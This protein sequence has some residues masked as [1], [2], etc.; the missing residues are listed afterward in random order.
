MSLLLQMLSI[1]LLHEIFIFL[2][3][4]DIRACR[5]TCKRFSNLIGD[6]SLLHYILLRENSC[7]VDTPS[8]DMPVKCRIE[9]LQRWE[10]AWD[11]LRTRTLGRDIPCPEGMNSR[12]YSICDGYLIGM[13]HGFKT[14][15]YYLSIHDPTLSS[16][17]G[18]VNWTSVSFQPYVPPAAC[19]FATEHNMTAIISV[20]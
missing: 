11:V 17:Q 2:P 16:P 7:I 9:A 14:G 12:T 15:Y 5:Q 10:R 1:E 8:T 3:P 4:C 13:H 20:L 6:S 18:D 19:V